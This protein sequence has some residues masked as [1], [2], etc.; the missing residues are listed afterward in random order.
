MIVLRQKLK[1]YLLVYILIYVVN[2]FIKAN[3][4]KTRLAFL[5]LFGHGR[6]YLGKA[7][8]YQYFAMHF[9]FKRDFS[10]SF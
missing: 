6:D 2:Y 4:F 3:F 1:I 9:L 8:F 5:L 7:G 10:Q